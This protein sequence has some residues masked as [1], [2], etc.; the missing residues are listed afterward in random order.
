MPVYKKSIHRSLLSGVAAFISLLCLL[1]SIQSYL[2]VSRALYARYEEQLANALTYLEHNID[3]DD[4]Q[5]CV[6][7]GAPSEKFYEAQRLENMMVDDLGL[8]YL[9]IC[10]PLDDET[11]TMVSVVTAT[12]A[13][14]RAAGEEDFPLLHTEPDAYT[15]EEL[16]PYLAAW[17]NTG[18]ITFFETQFQKRTHDSEAELL[19]D[20]LAQAVQEQL[21]YVTQM[22]PAVSGDLES[23]Y[24]TAGGLDNTS[25]RFTLGA[26]ADHPLSAMGYGEIMLTYADSFGASQSYG[27]IPS[28]N[29]IGSDGSLLYA[30]LWVNC[31][32]D[33][34]AVTLNV[35]D[36][37]E[38]VRADRQFVVYPALDIFA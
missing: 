11:G 9:Y 26:S 23:F 19:C 5:R 16:V 13:E 8:T 7:T 31:E 34:F 10:I 24:S 20:M 17:D 35:Y 37:T 33:R 15:K 3:A 32:A 12:S 30:F 38:K 4:M 6:H 22:T 25:C 1:L 2:M 21:T 28:A 36:E 27:L 18:E 14:E 29:Y